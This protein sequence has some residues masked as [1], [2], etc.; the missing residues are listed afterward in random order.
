MVCNKHYDMLRKVSRT[1]ALSI[2]QLPHP[3][4]D[5]ITIAYLMFRVADCIEDHDAMLPERKAI[6]LRQWAGVLQGHETSEKFLQG[7]SD[8]DANGDPEVEVAL[9][10]D[11]V[12]QALNGLPR[13]PRDILIRHVGDTSV[14]MARWQE[15]GPFVED[16]AAMDDYMHEVAGRVGYLLTEVFAWYD[17]KIAANIEI[18]MQLGREFGL[19]LQTVNI[20]RGMRK[21]YERGWVF[22][23]Q[24]MYEAEGLT[25]DS[26]FLPENR[27]RAMRVVACL[28]DK[29]EQHLA[30]GLAYIMLLPSFSRRI[31]LF[32]IWPLL[33]AV[34]TLALSRS[35]PAVISSEAKI[36]RPQVKRI[37][38]ISSLIWWSDLLLGWYYRMLSK[39]SRT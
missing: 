16:E 12:V 30:N 21:D 23:P 35:N 9:Q 3:V 39:P 28:A 14:G 13:I 37:V 4:C 19:A 22:V 11:E 36:T 2:E 24:C 10:A 18:L 38:A 31:R 20:I 26:M 32:C 33:F 5:I 1:F 17:P 7:M 8:I 25:R 27:E 6:L 15:H 34:K 29:A